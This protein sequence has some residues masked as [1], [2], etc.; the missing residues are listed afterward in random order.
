[1]YSSRLVVVIVV[2]VVVVVAVVVVAVAVV[3]AVTV[4][5]QAYS[6]FLSSSPKRPI[7][8]SSVMH[9]LTAVYRKPGL[10]WPSYCVIIIGQFYGVN[11]KEEA[12]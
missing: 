3:V 8:S 7:T 11:D 6:S 9:S 5:L 4:A 1:V 12:K 10:L 2:V